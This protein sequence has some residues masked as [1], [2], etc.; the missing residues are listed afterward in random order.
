MHTKLFHLFE[1]DDEAFPKRSIIDAIYRWI[2]L[3]Q[4]RRYLLDNIAFARIDQMVTYESKVW[5]FILK[6]LKKAP[7]N[8]DWEVKM[9]GILCW[10]K[11]LKIGSEGDQALDGEELECDKDAFRRGIKCLGI[12]CAQQGSRILVQALNDC[13]KL[14][15][16]AALK[17]LT[18]IKN[19]CIAEQHNKHAADITS[20]FDI[21]MC[22]ID[23]SSSD[24]FLIFLKRIDFEELARSM[25]LADDKVVNNPISLLNDIIAAAQH[26]DDNLLDCY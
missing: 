1:E 3:T 21:K 14:V 10:E 6:V 20:C 5:D 2:D 13:D 25:R 23:F 18:W 17:T 15:C 8:F 12:V 7:L 9:K 4:L 22:D 16:D 26:N 11:I 24:S 19:N